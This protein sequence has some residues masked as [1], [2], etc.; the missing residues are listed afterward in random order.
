MEEVYEDIGVSEFKALIGT[1]NT[2]LLDV[3]TPEEEIEGDI[4]G[5]QLINFSE[6]DFVDQIGAAHSCSLEPNAAESGC[7]RQAFM[8]FSRFLRAKTVDLLVPLFE[9]CWL[10]T[11]GFGARHQDGGG[12]GD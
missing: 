12:A 9:F 6:P 5:K 1:E 8:P 10:L 7:P 2:V 4:D 11:A 3:R